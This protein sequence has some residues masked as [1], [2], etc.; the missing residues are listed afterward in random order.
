MVDDRQQLQLRLVENLDAGADE[1]AQR[2][3]ERWGNPG[4]QRMT[5]LA[6]LFPCLDQADGIEPWDPEALIR[7]A[8]AGL[9]STTG[10]LHAVRF[11]L[12]VWSP[13]ANGRL[14]QPACWSATGESRGRLGSWRGRSLRSTSW[15]RSRSG[16]TATVPR[17]WIGLS[18]PFLGSSPCT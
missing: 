15:S 10:M 11:V 4:A 13:S 2:E 1:L 14:S 16:M 5:Q 8:A 12:Q 7:W 9:T 3:R 17:F 18:C 6:R